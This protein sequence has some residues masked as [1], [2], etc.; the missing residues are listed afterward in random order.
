MDEYIIK[1]Q[2]NQKMKDKVKLID[3]YDRLP[4]HKKAK[5]MKFIDSLIPV[6]LHDDK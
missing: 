5:F 1:E 3:F 4:E 2:D 6:L